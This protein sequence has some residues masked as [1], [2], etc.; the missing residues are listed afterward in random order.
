MIQEK[1]FVLSVKVLGMKKSVLRQLPRAYAIAYNGNF[2]PI[3]WINATIIGG[4]SQLPAIVG[5]AGDNPLIIYS[6]IGLG[7]GRDDAGNIIIN[8]REKEYHVP[9]AVVE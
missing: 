6:S 2:V 9:F 1:Q 8:K 3:C 7:Y 5:M 4:N